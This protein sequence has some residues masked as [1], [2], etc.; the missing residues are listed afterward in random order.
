MDKKFAIL[1]DIHANI[2]ALKTVV[3]DARSRSVT[4]FICV[5]DI[6]GYNAS[7][8]ECVDLIRELDCFTEIGRASCRERV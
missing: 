1:G 3:E 5:G 6:V 7:P 8:N 2:D 4:D